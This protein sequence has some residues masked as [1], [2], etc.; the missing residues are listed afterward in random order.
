VLLLVVARSAGVAVLVGRTGSSAPVLAAEGK[1]VQKAPAEAAGTETYT[2]PAVG[3]GAEP[4]PLPS[5]PIAAEAPAV[6]EEKSEPR[7]AARPEPAPV[8]VVDAAP[9]P[10]PVKPVAEP[11]PPKPAPVKAAAAK[12]VPKP[13]P[14][15]VKVA[16]A[17]PPSME[18]PTTPLPTFEAIERAQAAVTEAPSPPPALRHD[19]PVSLAPGRAAEK[20]APLLE[21]IN[22]L[23]RLGQ[24]ERERLG[25]GD[26][27]LNVLREAS[28]SQPEGLAII[29][30]KKVFVGEMIPGTNARLLAVKTRMIA[31]EIEGTGERFKV[32]N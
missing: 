6:P 17:A 29:N 5:A 25:L 1:P 20:R 21:D 9:L 13:A 11:I 8:A 4:A 2:V 31:I 27:R 12:P 32:T 15:P 28:A 30:L 22:T 26:L 19:P 3:S 24:A 7:P 16:K 10:E 18:E 14:A 23:P